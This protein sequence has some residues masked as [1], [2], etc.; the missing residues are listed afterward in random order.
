[1]KKVYISGAITHDPLYKIKFA[2]AEKIIKDE[3]W[4]PINPAKINESIQNLPYEDIMDVCM[5]LIDIADA[6]FMLDT[7]KDSIG[8]NREYGYALGCDKLICFQK[9]FEKRRVKR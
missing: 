4:T 7:W 2:E 5:T 1:M 3:G 6:V 9:D 8:A